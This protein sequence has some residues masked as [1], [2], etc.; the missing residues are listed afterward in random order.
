MKTTI[1]IS[2]ELH[3]E[4]RKRKVN[5]K[6]TYED[7]IWNLIEA[8][9]ELSEETKKHIIQSQKEIREGKVHKLGDVKKELRL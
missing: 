6:Y 9:M 4:L 1:Q 8:H 2:P 7:I 5:K 3:N